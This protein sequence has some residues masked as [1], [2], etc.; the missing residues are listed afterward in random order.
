M[1]TR[2]LISPRT[3]ERHQKYVLRMCE[4]TSTMRNMCLFYRLIYSVCEDML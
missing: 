2:G 4:T 1:I 3:L